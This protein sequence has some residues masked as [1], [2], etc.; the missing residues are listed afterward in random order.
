MTIRYLL[1]KGDVRFLIYTISIDFS[2][3]QTSAEKLSETALAVLY[4]FQMKTQMNFP[5]FVGFYSMCDFAYA[6]PLFNIFRQTGLECYDSVAVVSFPL[7]VVQ[8]IILD[9]IFHPF[10]HYGI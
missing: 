6:G 9:V 3:H 8:L 7:P 2:N 10:Y 1:K 5:K 4:Q